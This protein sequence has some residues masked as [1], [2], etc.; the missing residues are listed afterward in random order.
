[1]RLHGNN[2]VQTRCST[3]RLAR[4]VI[5]ACLERAEAEPLTIAD[6]EI[7]NVQCS[8]LTAGNAILTIQALT[9]GYERYVVSI[10]AVREA[11]GESASGGPFGVAGGRAITY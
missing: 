1:M 11:H 8:G 6:E 9:F 4:D 3:N 2:N 5:L 10:I 7:N